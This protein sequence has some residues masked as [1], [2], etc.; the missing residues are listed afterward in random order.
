MRVF[1]D[2]HHIEIRAFPLIDENFV[3]LVSYDQVPGVDGAISAHER[4]ENVVCG[5][6]GGLV[7]LGE[8]LDD[9]IAGG[10]HIVRSS[11]EHI[12]FPL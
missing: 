2:G 5:E 8:V 1:V 4:A 6:Y 10:G 3:V 9:R 12:E 7:L 11:L